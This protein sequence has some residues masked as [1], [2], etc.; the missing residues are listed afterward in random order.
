M[1]SW[2]SFLGWGGG[3]LARIDCVLFVGLR[4]VGGVGRS[5]IGCL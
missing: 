4:A 2:R 5:S 3:W 1:S